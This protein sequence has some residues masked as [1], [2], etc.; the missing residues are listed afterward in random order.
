MNL[1]LPDESAAIGFVASLAVTLA[2]LA[3]V[4][5]TGRAAKRKVHIPLVIGAVASLGV[6]IYFAEKLGELY[7]LESA[8]VIYPI[9]LALAK[10]TTVGYLLPLVTGV[11]TVR[12]A[13]RIVWH[14]RCAYFI[15]VMTVLTAATGTT[16]VLMAE[17]L[18]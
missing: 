4:V 7:D 16:M 9:H 8:G 18:G 17:R 3:G 15:L 13:T 12:D 14:R 11:L 5:V 2:I 1:S 6:T 10:T